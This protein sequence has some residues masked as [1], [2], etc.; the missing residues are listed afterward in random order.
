MPVTSPHHHPLKKKGEGW[1]FISKNPEAARQ[2]FPYYWVTGS[3]SME[4]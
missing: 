3:F 1:E 4:V 2:P